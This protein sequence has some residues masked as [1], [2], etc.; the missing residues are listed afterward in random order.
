MS[1][2]ILIN[3]IYTLEIPTN[4]KI[5]LDI[6]PGTD[7]VR[8]TFYRKQGIKLNFK[9]PIWIFQSWS[10]IRE[11]QEFSYEDLAAKLDKYPFLLETETEFTCQTSR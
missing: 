5:T 10:M 4:W 7:K 3:K 6:D 8:L 9:R 11:Y 2:D 1:R